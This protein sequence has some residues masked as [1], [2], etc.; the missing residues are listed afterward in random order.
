NPGPAAGHAA[1]H[2]GPGGARRPVPPGLDRPG[3]GA[4]HPGRDATL[5]AGTAHADARSG[6][7][8]RLLL[9]LPGADPADGGGLPRPRPG[10]RLGPSGQ[11]RLDQRLPPLGLGAGVPD[12]L[13]GGRADARHPLRLVLPAAARPAAARQRRADADAAPGAAPAGRRRGLARAVPQAAGHRRDQPRRAFDPRLR[14]ARLA[15]ADRPVPAAAALV[16]GAGADRKPDP[17]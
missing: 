16:L 7:L 11:P 8:P 6:R 4:A 2:A 1:R 13:G 14:A 3:A 10:T 5:A 17:G 12:R 15:A 9:L